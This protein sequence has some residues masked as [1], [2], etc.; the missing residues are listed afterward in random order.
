MGWPWTW[1]I[2]GNLEGNLGEMPS[3]PGKENTS[4][5]HREA[6]KHVLVRSLWAASGRARTR[7]KVEWSSRAGPA[8]E[9]RA[10]DQGLA[11]STT[12]CVTMTTHSLHWLW[13]D[14]TGL[15]AFSQHA[16]YP[17]L[18]AFAPAV[19][20]AYAVFSWMPNLLSHFMQISAHWSGHW[21]TR[22]ATIS[23]QSLS[24]PFLALFV[25]I[26]LNSYPLTVSLLPHRR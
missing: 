7:V 17:Y 13:S 14:H 4:V 12:P 11:A 9:Q 20:C 15:L 26:A 24:P 22:S 23:F 25:F 18:R 3:A 10:S 16:V 5:W 1:E 19:P 8:G 6:T 21:I 2:Q